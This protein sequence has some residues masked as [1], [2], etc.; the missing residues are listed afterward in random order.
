MTAVEAGNLNHKKAV[1]R[2]RSTQNYVREIRKTPLKK[3]K[4]KTFENRTNVKEKST[5]LFL[6][7]C[8]T[9]A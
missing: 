5:T 7:T 8:V 2:E 6:S 3:N 9:P 1:K 4:Y